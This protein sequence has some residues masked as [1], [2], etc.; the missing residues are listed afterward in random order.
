MKHHVYTYAYFCVY[1]IKV[2]STYVPIDFSTR[3]VLN[4]P[5]AILAGRETKNYVPRFGDLIV[6]LGKFSLPN[7]KFAQSY[8]HKSTAETR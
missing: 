2:C 5:D 6:A 8:C 1:Y 3:Y 4:Q 7:I